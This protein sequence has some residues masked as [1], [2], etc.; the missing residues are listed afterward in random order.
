MRTIRLMNR[1][2]SV[3]HAYELEVQSPHATLVGLDGRGGHC[4]LR[5]RLLYHYILS[6]FSFETSP[7]LLHLGRCRKEARYSFHL[8]IIRQT[9]EAEAKVGRV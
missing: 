9:E 4:S 5:R 6:S 1:L 8:P 7:S 3:Q 2:G